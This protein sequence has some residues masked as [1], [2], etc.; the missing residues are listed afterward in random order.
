MGQ[1]RSYSYIYS[2][3]RII[4]LFFY[5]TTSIS[6]A[7]PLIKLVTRLSPN[8]FYPLVVTLLL[9]MLLVV[10]VGALIHVISYIPFHLAK[11]FDPIQNDI[12]SGR[13]STMDQLG[14]RITEFTV[15]F[16]SFSFL[17]ISHAYIQT[18]GSDLRGHEPNSQVENVLKDYKMLQKSQ[19]MDG[20]IRAG[21]IS[22]PEGD[23][24]LYILPIWFGTRWLG[25]MALLSHKRISP[26]F[27]RFLIE[28]EDNFLDDQVMLM[29][30]YEKK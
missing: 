6:L 30:H 18:E 13:I 25:Y 1:G 15:Q 16:Y 2:V 10:V 9:Y 27:Q 8:H 11:A 22:L 12:A 3:Q 5:T 24:H 21:E 23:F 29:L 17:D 20:I 4:L 28:Y 19:E 14:E 26:F 7:I